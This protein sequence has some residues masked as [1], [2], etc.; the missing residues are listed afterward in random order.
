MPSTAGYALCKEDVH[1]KCNTATQLTQNCHLLLHEKRC[2]FRCAKCKLLQ[3]LLHGKSISAPL[4]AL[5]NNQNVSPIYAILLSFGFAVMVLLIVSTSS[6][7]PTHN[8]RTQTHI[9]SKV[10]VQSHVSGKTKEANLLKVV[11]IAA[12]FKK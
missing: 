1:V 8:T 10:R 9:H 6:R 4:R 12:T 3:I 2:S 5:S 11:L 7:K